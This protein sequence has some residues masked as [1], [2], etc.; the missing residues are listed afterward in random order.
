MRTESAR[1]EWGQPLPLTSPLPAGLPSINPTLGT[2][3]AFGVTQRQTTVC[4]LESINGIYRLVGWKELQRQQGAALAQQG[5]AICRQLGDELGRVLWDEA[6]SQPF[7][8]SADPIRYPPIEH[9]S[10]AVSPRTR[11]RVWLAGLTLGE[12]LE[13]ARLA[14]ASAPLE[15]IGVTHL[16][17]DLDSRQL[18]TELT[19]RQ[20][21][22]M[23]L[24]GGY[25]TPTHATHQWN[26]T[27]ARHVGQALQRLSPGQRPTIFYAGNQSAAKEIEALLQ[28]ME[29]RLNFQTVPNILPYPGYPRPA[30]L[31]VA[32]SQLYWQLCQ[33]L[34]G[35][36]QLSR[37]VTAPGHIANLES[38]FAQLVQVWMEYQQLPHL[39]GLFC[40]PDWWLHV[41][42][43]QDGVQLCFVQPHTRPQRLSQWPTVQFVSGEWPVDLWPPPDQAWWDR[44]GLG[45]LIT[46]IGQVAPQAMLQVLEHDLIET[47]GTR[48]T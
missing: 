32:L 31:A 10:V 45:P 48:A 19:E 15:L 6:N 22:A 1:V 28:Q 47:R 17:A 3:M 2:L 4:L 25:D 26:V 42:A 9:I 30:A 11:M 16:T 33:R 37:W 23:V 29:G 46:T 34:P 41:W 38:S 8:Q 39:H 27:L 44:T 40:T 7:L 5:T 20:P 12:S 36:S 35:F 24:V 21:E 18:A 14:L 13:T 43:N